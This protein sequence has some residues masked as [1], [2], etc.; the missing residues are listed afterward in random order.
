MGLN[1]FVYLVSFSDTNI[2]KGGDDFG[3]HIDCKESSKADG[4]R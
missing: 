3:T 4:Q 2:M 1:F